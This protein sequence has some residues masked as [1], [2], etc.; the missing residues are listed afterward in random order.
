MATYNRP[1]K[2]SDRRRRLHYAWRKALYLAATAAVV[3]LLIAADRLG[4]LGAKPPSDFDKYHQRTFLVVNVVDGDTLDVDWPDGRWPHTRIRLLGVDTPETVK[5]DTPPQHFGPE[6]G[7][8]TRNACLGKQVRVELAPVRNRD[9]YGRLLGY[10]VL[11]DE[12]MLNRLLVA[13]GY[14]YADPRFDHPHKREFLSLQRD[15][16]KKRIG[17][18]QDVRR[19]DLPYY[20][21]DLKLPPRPG[22]EPKDATDTRASR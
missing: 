2:M 14:G 20:Y 9:T 16:R 11:P 12:R 7:R 19:A 21:S 8:F 10:V 1:R 3:A 18:W 15:A 17:L 6:A 22:P 5:P 4:L 13:R